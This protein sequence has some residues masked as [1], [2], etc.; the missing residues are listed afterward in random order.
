MSSIKLLVIYVGLS[1]VSYAFCVN[2]Y[3]DYLC[4]I[5]SVTKAFEI[6]CEQIFVFFSPNFHNMIFTI[7][8]FKQL[9]QVMC[10]DENEARAYVDGL[11][12]ELNERKNKQS[13]ASW[14]AYVNITEENE[15]LEAA[16]DLENS[17]FLKVC[18]SI[19]VQN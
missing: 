15:K 10:M 6:S 8:R 3:V 5:F 9:S 7:V 14:N 16:I 17:Q 19:F 4:K 11:N 12:D 1:V 18:T 13:L 2:C